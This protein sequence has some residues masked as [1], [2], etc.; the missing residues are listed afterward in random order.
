MT[1]SVFHALPDL[2]A[3]LEPRGVVHVGAHKGQEVPD[4]RAAGFER[5]VLIEPNPAMWRHLD[6]LDDVTVHRCACGP[7]GTATL[8]VT[9]ASQRSSL[10]EPT[11]WNVTRTVDVPVRP[12]AELQGGCN[13][14]VVDVQGCEL[15]VLATADLP[16]L[17]LI[18]VEVSDT[19]RYRSAPTRDA[20]EAFLTAAGW[21]MV[22]EF[23]GGHSTGIADTAWRRL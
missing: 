10:L 12:L 14:A 8:H 4:Y 16:A 7:T 3:D 20:L 13:V 1:A 17:E 6:R 11:D 2:L 19:V 23:R 22:A 18:V 5:I 9:A 15:D 21:S